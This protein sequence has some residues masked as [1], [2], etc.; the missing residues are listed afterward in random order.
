MELPNKLA[1]QYNARLK[2]LLA[3]LNENL[4]GATFVH[5]NVYDLVMEVITNYDKY[6]KYLYRD[7][8]EANSR[9]LIISR[10]EY[11]FFI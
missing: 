5:A 1:L 8:N 6:G 2:D 9:F 4:P 10:Q 3:S 7:F 11:F